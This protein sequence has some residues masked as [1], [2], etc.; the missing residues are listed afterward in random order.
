M[1]HPKGLVRAALRYDP[2]MPATRVLDQFASSL[3]TTEPERQVTLA[4]IQHFAEWHS[5]RRQS[6]PERFVPK[7]GDD[8]GLA[9]AIAH[10]FG[11]VWP[12]ESLRWG[13][14]WHEFGDLHWLLA[15]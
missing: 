13:Y 11:A 2:L 12:F 3:D 14:L 1:R 8:V 5:Q 4:H 7:G 10:L 9:A 6:A 15:K